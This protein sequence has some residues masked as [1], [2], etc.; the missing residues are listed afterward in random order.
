MPIS[1][2]AESAFRR[3]RA[4]SA[5]LPGAESLDYISAEPVLGFRSL[6]LAVFYTSI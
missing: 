6:G 3:V 4:A 1:L 5:V 2:Y